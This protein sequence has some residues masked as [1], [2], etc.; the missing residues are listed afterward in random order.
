M[1]LF[2]GWSDYGIE[3]RDA[4]MRRMGEGRPE[5]LH[6]GTVVQSMYLAA[7]PKARA[8]V[9]PLRLQ[10]GFLYE[11]V[12]EFMGA[13]MSM[14]D[15]FQ[16][17]FKRYMVGLNEGIITQ[18]SVQKDGIWMTP[19]AVDS[20]RGELHSYKH[21]RRSLKR[22]LDGESFQQNFWTW[23]V[24]EKGY[25]YACAVDTTRFIVLWAAGD[26]SSGVGSA[27]R[28][29]QCTLKWTVAELLDNWQAVLI[30]AHGLR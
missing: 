11:K 23:M 2:S 29:L 4:D 18:L 10:E 9:E 7:D 12:V 17:A 1:A 16:L 25:A 22:A 13:G 28:A 6:L 5:G 26:Y 15:S 14:D 20:A 30:H 21:T 3:L 24:A 8:E 27:P 19:D